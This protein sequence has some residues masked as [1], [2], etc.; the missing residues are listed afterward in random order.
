MHEEWLEKL[1][2]T[3]NIKNI[4]QGKN[5]IEI[6]IP[7]EIVETLDGQKLFIGVSRISRMF[8]FSKRGNNLIIILDIVKL[9]KHFVYY[10]IELFE[11][12]K[13]IKTA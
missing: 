6:T 7:K 8:R 13:K 1:A 11:L 10:L 9:D 5:S 2:T 12:I 4:R 3:L